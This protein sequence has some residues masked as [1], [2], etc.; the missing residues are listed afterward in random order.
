MWQVCL[1]SLYD[2]F[3]WLVCLTS[4]SDKFVWQVFSASLSDKYVWQVCV[5]SLCGKFVWLV[6]P[7]SLT[8]KFNHLLAV[9]VIQVFVWLFE[10]C[11]SC[12][13]QPHTA[14]ISFDSLKFSDCSFRNAIHLDAMH[15][16]VWD[17]NAKIK[18][19]ICLF[20]SNIKLP[21]PLRKI[22]FTETWLHPFYIL[23]L[24]SYF[25]IL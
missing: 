23:Q 15:C 11:S 4:W 20:A 3:V 10:N 7:A 22:T 18:D 21:N 16:N 24:L 12:N 6:Y 13:Y 1:T 8:D 17:R 9:S 5:T 2:K 14:N 25:Q 19:D